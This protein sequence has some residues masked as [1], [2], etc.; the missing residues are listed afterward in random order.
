MSEPEQRRLPRSLVLLLAV[1]VGS[2]VA[3]LYYVQP[4]LNVIADDLG[5]SDTAAGLLVTCAQLGYVAGLALIVPL[6]DL[7]ER[8]R[9]V[10]V[11]LGGAGV[12]LAVSAASPSFAVLRRRSSPS[13]RCR[14]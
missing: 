11:L 7:R 13:A 5:V 4:L 3:N 6:G 2:T 9:L 8:S 14:A 12:A 1:A 10:T